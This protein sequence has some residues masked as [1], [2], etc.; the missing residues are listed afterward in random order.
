MTSAERT[1]DQARQQADLAARQSEENFRRV[2][3]EAAI[4]IAISDLQ[5]RLL[6]ANAAYCRMLGYTEAELRGL[7]FASITHPDDRERNR[8][9]LDELIAGRR[10]AVVHEK[11]Y[12]AKDGRVVWGR[13]SLSIQHGADGRPV[14]IIG[15]AEDITAART[16]MEALS[17][18]E[19]RFRLLARAT[20]D[21]VWDWDIGAD[22][23]WWNE[24]Y[25]GLF[26]HPQVE[27]PALDSWVAFIHPDDVERVNRSLQSVLATGS[28]WQDEYRF[29]HRQGHYVM[30]LDRGHV[31]RDGAGR[32]VRMVGGMSDLTERRR[33]EHQL[34]E[35]AALLDTAHDAILVRDGEHRITYWNRGAERLYGWTAAE[36]RGRRMDE[37]LKIDAERFAEACASVESAGTWN[38][39]ISKVAKNGSVRLVDASWSLQ[40]D[41]AG[42]ATILTIDTDITERRS[43]EQQFL[44]AQRMESIGTLAGGIAHD[45]N[46]LLAPIT[47]SIELLRQNEPNPRS[48][49]LIDNI[50]R[51]ARRG[52]ALIKQVLSFARGMEGS[53]VVLQL[54]HV[55]REI[56]GIIANTFPREITLRVEAPGDLWPV[57]GDPTQLNQVLLNLCVNAR[58]AMPEGGQLRLAAANLEVDEQYAVMNRGVAPGRYVRIEVVDSGTGIPRDI[59][60]RIFEPFFTTKQPGHG[61]GL[62]LSTVLGI[63]RGH[64]GFVNVYSEV[65]EG[66]TFKVYLPAQPEAAATSAEAPATDPLPRGRGEL[67]LVVDDEVPIL[68]VTRQTLEVFGYRVLTAEDGA[69]AIGLYAIQREQ[70][71]LVLTDMMMPVMNGPALIAA[72]RRINPHVRIIAASGLGANAD[73]A[74]A[75]QSGVKHFLAKPYTADA[76]LVLVHRVMNSGSRPPV[77]PPPPAAGPGAA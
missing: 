25:T 44:R 36:A 23:V 58:D 14:R 75:M 13:V 32:A 45:L 47:M 56:E 35:Q 65:G 68:N 12:L 8:Q 43:L 67:V 71:A 17:A 60:E 39:E 24:G 37:L 72:L 51:S 52:A 5:P 63:V 76:M 34:R 16:A 42:Q 54:R 61:T 55:L 70:I 40:R 49:L 57:V 21:A 6:E 66:S 73:V 1:D 19:E 62:G 27:G 11:R 9:V 74:R 41:A 4:G 26:G 59:I 22:R 29:R 38:G 50:E 7:D 15:V 69:Q 46:N 53:R 33:A 10:A 64:G 48:Q 28:T 31:L 3:Q 18:S 30:V 77:D 2:F 20:N